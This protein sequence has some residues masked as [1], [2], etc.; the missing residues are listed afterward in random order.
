MIMEFRTVK[1]AV[2]N[3][4]GSAAAG[5]YRV[6]GYKPR[7][8]APEEANDSLR[9]VQVFYADGK[10]P[11]SGGGSLGPVAHDV[12]LKIDLAVAC[13]AKGD[14]SVLENPAATAVQLAAA[15]DTFQESAETADDTM[16]ALIDAIFNILMSGENLDL[17]IADADISNRWINA[18]NKEE[19]SPR[20]EYVMINAAMD[21]SFRVAEILD[22]DTG[23]T[24]D[25]VLGA[26]YTDVE[27]NMPDSASADDATAALRGGGI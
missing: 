11:R 6:V 2:V 17:G 22:G 23:T 27:T 14:L 19:P 15:L 24:A 7:A 5:R 1:T 10:F 13:A 3:L 21:L 12:T 16:D 4:L 26:V 9:T 25:P 20:G 8:M 18:I